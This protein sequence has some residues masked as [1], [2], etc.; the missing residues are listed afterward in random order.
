MPNILIVEDD[1]A[2]N[3][4]IALS[5]RQDNYV[6][7]QGFS[8]RQA[9]E[10]LESHPVDLV[11]L[12]INLPDGS[13]FELCRQI[14]ATSSLPIIFL[15]ANDL[16]VDIVTGLELG[17][18]DYITK[19]FSLMV[20]RA[21]VSALLRRTGTVST[22]D[23]IIIDSFIFDFDNMQFYSNGQEVL[24]SKTEQKL[25]KLLV[26]NGGITLSRALLVDR[27]W[28]DGA[29]YVDENALSVAI[30]RLRSKL[31]K[32]PAHPEYIH[33]VYGTGYLW[34]ARTGIKHEQK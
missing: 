30:S 7:S 1:A 12:D 26:K 11:I 20:L 32:T 3:N 15:T 19:P 14:R 22:G 13:G 27:I 34:E 10:H 9:Q 17:G 8:L 29:E 28:T 4:G 2:L 31:E 25:L 16:E 24:L 23:R 5:L 6:L 33:T 21:R 18:D